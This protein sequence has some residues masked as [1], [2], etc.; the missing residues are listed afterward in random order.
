M[1]LPNFAL[2]KDVE[3][4]KKLVET[5]KLAVVANNSYAL[6]FDCE[7]VAGGALNVYNSAAAKFLNVPII[8]AE[9]SLAEKTKFAYMTL[10]HCPFKC[11]IGATCAKCPYGDGYTLKMQNGKAL[12]IK[13]KKLS[14]CTFYLTD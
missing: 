1:D 4:L 3:F 9:D 8:C 14:T 6:D 10:R 13:R 5:N 7:K 11:D 2:D 12:K